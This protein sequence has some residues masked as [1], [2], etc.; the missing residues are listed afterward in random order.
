M[1][2]CNPR[3]SE[4]SNETL[5]FQKDSLGKQYGLCFL[6]QEPDK[7]TREVRAIYLDFSQ[8]SVSFLYATAGLTFQF[9]N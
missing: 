8:Y 1:I 5:R 3:F 7:D 9:K 2:D 6:H 4:L